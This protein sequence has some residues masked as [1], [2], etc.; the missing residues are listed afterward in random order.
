MPKHK[1]GVIGVQGTGIVRK[2]DIMG[3]ITIPKEV[4]QKLNITEDV[5]PLELYIYGEDTII[6]RKYIPMDTCAIC[7]K[8]VQDNEEVVDYRDKTVCMDC[9]RELRKM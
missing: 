3:R 4:R 9:I 1:K 6:L 8:H 2:V 5:T 7:A